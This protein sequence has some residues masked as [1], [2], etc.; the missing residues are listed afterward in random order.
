MQTIT[1]NLPPHSRQ[2]SIS[3]VSTRLRRCIHDMGALGLPLST[4]ARVRRGTILDLYLKLGANS[5]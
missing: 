1:L 3:M 5:P 2:V 4:L